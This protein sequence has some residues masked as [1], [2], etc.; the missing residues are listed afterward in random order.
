MLAFDAGPGGQIGQAFEGGDELRAA[1]GIARVVHGIDAN[2]NGTGFEHFGPGQRQRQHDGVARRHIGHRDAGL[3]AVGG[4]GDVG[5]G[6][7]RAAKARQV[8]AEGAVGC[9]AQVVRHALCGLQFDVVT[10][11]VVQRQAVAAIAFGLG[12]GQHGGRIQPAVEQDDGIGG[13]GI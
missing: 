2:E 8:Q 1:I 4:Y 5:I 9:R 12:D 7:R 10:L 3:Q 11:T 6:Q 13:G